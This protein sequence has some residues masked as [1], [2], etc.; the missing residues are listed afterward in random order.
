MAVRRGLP[1]V[2]TEEAETPVGRAVG[3]PVGAGAVPV[4]VPGS[5]LVMVIAVIVVAAIEAHCEDVGDPHFLPLFYPS[6]SRRALNK[7]SVEDAGRRYPRHH[8]H[9]LSFPYLRP[10]TITKIN[11]VAHDDCTSEG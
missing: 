10:W 9:G 11:G 7:R 1:Q 4:A 5:V 8:L 6:Y 3:G 2:L